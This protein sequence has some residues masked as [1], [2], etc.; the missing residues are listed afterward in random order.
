MIKKL[1]P[2]V[3]LAANL[4]NKDLPL[5][6]KEIASLM[7]LFRREIDWET[8]WVETVTA[9]GGVPTNLGIYFC[10]D[11][12][13]RAFQ[14]KYRKLDRTTDI[15]SF[16]SIEGQLVA[17]EIDEDLSLGDL[18]VSLP[19]IERG[20]RRG[21]RSSKLELTEV[22]LHGALHLLGCDHVVP[23]ARGRRMA[24]RMRALQ[25]RIFADARKR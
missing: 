16:P 24:L 23:G 21:R 11:D 25:K 10:D 14:K 12:E 9:L 5:T 20:A 13:M 22:L 2:Q 8:E 18:I 4:K 15:L 1:R 7:A 3:Q 19:A 17:V 6:R